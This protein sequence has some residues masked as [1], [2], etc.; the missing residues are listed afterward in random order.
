MLVLFVLSVFKDKYTPDY[1]NTPDAFFLKNPDGGRINTLLTTSTFWVKA[2][3]YSLGILITSISS[4]HFF[5]NKKKLTQI[6]VLIN[7]VVLITIYLAIFYQNQWVDV[8]LVSK[9]NRYFHSP[10]LTLFLMAAF[11]ITELANDEKGL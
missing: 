7:V 9:L 2:I 10:I 6:T 5:F 1:R 11:K 4:V 3:F 8:V